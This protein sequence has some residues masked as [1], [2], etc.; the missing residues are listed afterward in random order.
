MPNVEKRFVC[1]RQIGFP[2][3]II[4]VLFL[5]LCLPPRAALAVQWDAGEIQDL[6]ERVTASIQNIDGITGN[7][8]NLS[9]LQDFVQLVKDSLQNI[10]GDMLEFLKQGRDEIESA[11]ADQAQGLDTFLGGNDCG[12]GSPCDQFKQN[13]VD[14]FGNLQSVSQ[15]L[16]QLYPGSPGGL[17]L[18]PRVFSDLI[19]AAPG[20]AI[21]PLYVG[22]TTGS[23][24][25][26]SDLSGYFALVQEALGYLKQGVVADPGAGV[27]R[28]Q[29]AALTLP[30]VDIP[31]RCPVIMEDI[32][33]DLFQASQRVLY[34]FSILSKVVAKI[35]IAKGETGF[36][37]MQLGIHGYIGG[38][39]SNNRKKK[40][41]LIV[42]GVADGA[43]MLATH[44]NNML[45]YCTIVNNQEQI[46]NAVLKDQFPGKGPTSTK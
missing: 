10:N 26:Q 36:S 15:T 2:P 6:K 42:E 13:I 39:L 37:G 4:G 34:G 45:R 35:L 33:P 9:N 23:N 41:G 29:N 25:F 3:F 1:R 16:F 44:A 32:G 20:K 19:A 43:G 12:A 8:G 21:Y 28:A 46:V 38:N 14:L 30:A 11:L 27:L 40:I 18:D 22:L 31:D 17:S 24:L 5:C 7:L